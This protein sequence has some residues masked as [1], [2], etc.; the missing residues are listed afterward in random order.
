MVQ[1]KELSPAQIGQVIRQGDFGEDILTS[2]EHVAVIMTQ[3]WCSQWLYMRNWLDE[4]YLNE[5]DMEIDIY[6][7]IYN[8][9]DYYEDFMNFKERVYKNDLI[10]Y[11]RYYKK[12]KFIGESN[13]IYKEDFLNLFKSF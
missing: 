11:V 4:L 1:Q 3:N 5:K 9:K 8:T 2:R 13:Y 6:E 7:I 10:P 12:G